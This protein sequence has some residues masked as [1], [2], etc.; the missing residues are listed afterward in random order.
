[1]PPPVSLANRP[2]PLPEPPRPLGARLRAWAEEALFRA[3]QLALESWHDFRRRD[4]WFQWKVGV[5]AAWALTSFLAIRVAMDGPGDL[6]ENGL[7]AYVAMNQTSMS[8]GLLVHNR[9]DEDWHEVRIVLEG[10]WVHERPTIAAGE[11]VVLSPSQFVREGIPATA[12]L[13]FSSVVV[14]TDDGRASPPIV[15]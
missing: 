15:R 8:W 12:E 1:M 3:R 6:A 13:E 4:R 5:V 7:Q 2:T 14:E 10:G 11:R 9:S